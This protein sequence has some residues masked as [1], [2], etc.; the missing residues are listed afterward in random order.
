[1][2]VGYRYVLTDTQCELVLKMDTDAL[3]I[4]EHLLTDAL[5]FAA[6]NPSVGMFGVYTHDYNRSRHFT[7]H[8]DQIRREL[9]GLRRVFG[10]QPSWAP[11]LARA[12]ERGYQRGDNVF[13][14]AYFITRSCLA[15]IAELGA[16]NVPYR[17]HST[18]AEDV[19]YSM[20]AVAAGYKLGHFAAPEGPMCMEWRGLPYPAEELLHAG[21][22]IVHSVDKGKNTGREENGGSTARE[23]FRN[24]RLARRCA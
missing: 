14:G 15:S 6:G 21:Y 17:W 23:V 18:L 24:A 5:S 12:E 11:L 20:A 10:A 13:G 16:L 9:R 8:S 22:K 7:S 19:Y 2:S 4:G 1:L 3:L